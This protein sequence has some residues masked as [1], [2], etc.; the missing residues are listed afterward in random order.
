LDEIDKFNNE[1]FFFK[2]ILLGNFK[3]FIIKK[4]DNFFPIS[5]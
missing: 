5:F 3:E 4:E 2:D 1:L